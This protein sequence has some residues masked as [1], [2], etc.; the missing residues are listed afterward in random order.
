MATKWKWDSAHRGKR[1][2]HAYCS[3]CK[4]RRGRNDGNRRLRHITRLMLKKEN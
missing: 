2:G 3:D 4:T 1:C